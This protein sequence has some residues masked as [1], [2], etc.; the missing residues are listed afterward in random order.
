MHDSD[1]MDLIQVHDFVHYGAVASGWDKR[2]NKSS[3]LA[4]EYL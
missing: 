3:S 2:H 1:P 4:M